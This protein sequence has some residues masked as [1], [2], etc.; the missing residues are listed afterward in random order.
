MRRVSPNLM[1]ASHKK[2]APPKGPRPRMAINTRSCVLSATA[3]SS[4]A[5]QAKDKTP[6]AAAKPPT[7]A[8][9][10]AGK[11]RVSSE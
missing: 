5:W 3:G 9:G 8:V 4:S 2:K 11:R 7:A 1:A 6:E 10:N